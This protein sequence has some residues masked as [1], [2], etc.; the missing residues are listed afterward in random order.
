MILKNTDIKTLLNSGKKLVCFGAGK[1]LKNC[2]GRFAAIEFANRIH[3]VL[4]DNAVRFEWEDLSFPV[5]TLENFLEEKADLH[6]VALLIT[7]IS[8][9]EVFE[10][11]QRSS[12]LRDTDCYIYPFV[13]HMPPPYE[14]PEPASGGVQKIPKKIHYIW[15]GS[16]K[17]PEKNRAWMESWEKHCPD[18]EII[19]WDDRNYDVTKHPYMH[20]AYKAKKYALASDYARLDIVYEHGGICFDTDVEVLDNL[21]GL[22]YDEAFFGFCG[23]DSISNGWGFG[24]IKSFNVLEE[25][26]ALFDADM[27]E[28]KSAQMNVFEKHGLVRNNSL[29][30]IDGMRIYPTDVFAPIN[31]VCSPVAFT[32][33]TLTVHHYDSSWDEDHIETRKAFLPICCTQRRFFRACIC[34]SEKTRG[35]YALRSNT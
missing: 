28:H 8:Y 22:L 25:M 19:Q 9:P 4:D 33:N 10:R 24:A 3:R 35:P 34:K 23:F 1:M 30:M 29:Q 6:S 12:Q 7:C 2:C 11:L 17:I 32:E 13:R 20:D 26:R 15:F 21:D 18:Y 14:F 5:Y 27:T 16:E 31:Y